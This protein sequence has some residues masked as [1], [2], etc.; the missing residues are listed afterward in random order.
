MPAAKKMSRT[1]RNYAVKAHM[2]AGKTFTAAT[3]AVSA[4]KPAPRKKK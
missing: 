1:A 3:K 2:A 4:G